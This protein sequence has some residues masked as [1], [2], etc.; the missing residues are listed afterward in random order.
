MTKNIYYEAKRQKIKKRFYRFISHLTFG[1]THTWYRDKY[2]QASKK[3]R[4][5]NDKINAIESICNTE[6]SPT[7]MLKYKEYVNNLFLK[8]KN[9]KD[10]FIPITETPFV[11]DDTDTKII[12][13]YLPQYYKMDIND[14]FHGKGFTEW[15]NTSQCLPLYTGHEQPHI[16]YDVGYYDL[17]NPE[18]LKRQAELAKMYGVYGFC[19]HWYWFSGARTMEKPL[20][21]L[22]KHK[23][24]DINYCFNWATENWTA[25]WDGGN[26]EMM[27]KQE[28]KPGDDKKLFN[29]L[30][31]Y[32]KDKRYIKIDG[33]PLF[34]IYNIR[35]FDKERAILLIKNLRKYAKEAGFK[36]LFITVTNFD[37]FDEDVT[38]W[39]AD[40]LNEFPP[41]FTHGKKYVPEGYLYPGFLGYIHDARDIINNKKY[42]RAY[43][44]KKY[45]RSAMVSWDNTARKAYQ[46]KCRI[47][48]GL[49]P[50]TFKT[51]L[52]D[53][54][55]ESKKIHKQSEDI[56]FVNSWNEWAEGSHLEPCMRYG[57]AYLQTVKDVLDAEK[58][59]NCDIVKNKIVAHKGKGALNFYVS[60]V[61]SFGDIVA[62]EPIARWLKQQAP[63]STVH[64]IVKKQ[65]HD[66]VAFNPNIDDV[67]DVDCLSDSIDICEKMSKSKNNI[68][69]DCHYD[70]RI[71]SGTHRVHTNKNNPHINEKTYFDMGS[72]LE[73][74]C[75]SAGMP[76]LKSAPEFHLKQDVL[77][78]DILPK[79]YIVMHCKSAEKIKD[80]SDEKW[81]KLAS[82]LMH[83]GYHIVE[84]GMQKTIK[85][86]SHKYHNL[87]HITD[88]QELA[89][90][91]SG[92]ML[93]TSVDSGFAHIAN[94]FKIPS[95]I[96]MGKYKT[97][98][99]PMPYTGF[100]RDNKEKY[101]MFANH[102][103]ASTIE[104][105]DVL[106]NVLKILGE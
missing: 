89:K 44:T 1:K 64:W 20:E 69:I 65:Y 39:G 47:F 6:V 17:L 77:I 74:F 22:L 28:L 66:L 94:C 48:H 2:N 53:I 45:F 37:N 49:N 96:I 56:C 76:V 54:V 7:S 30:L 97:F 104:E 29:D 36:D 102:A 4:I 14:K 10:S 100:L 40:A 33:K 82:D 41:A 78:S 8:N 18:T 55:R 63:K 3:F 85:S 84:I 31:P 9:R 92:A 60:C 98:D 87:T 106:D 16:P 103:P 27:F 21:L 75:M 50:S 99:Y 13:Y 43:K 57:Y 80:W 93:F 88:F 72:I 15:T 38:E 70:G 68:I 32:F 24:I 86:N 67:I 81:N 95:C 46:N 62:C 101:I 90:V 59:V 11:R 26:N 19:M 105:K 83:K 35:I 91:I 52:Q 73:T 34:S 25:L 42:M 23:E 51:W 5:A 58:P 61:E 79:Q 12:A 71:C